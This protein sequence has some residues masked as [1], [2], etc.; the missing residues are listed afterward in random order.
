MKK[1]TKFLIILLFIAEKIAAQD[2][3]TYAGLAGM[4]GSNDGSTTNAKF[5]SP[6][7]ICVDKQG[8]IYVADRYN[9][10]IRKI[11]TAG[12]VS[13]LAGSGAA[14]SNDATG[15]T[16]TFT[17]PWA[18][19]CDTLGNLYVAD[20]K[21][22]KIRKVNSSTGV[23]TT[24]AGTGTFGTTNGS[25]S[26]AQFGFPTGIAVSNDGSIIY[27]SD[28]MTHVIRKIQSGTVSTLAG[29]IYISGNTN[30][31][32]TAAKFDHPYSICLDNSGNIL[33]ADEW[34]NMIRKIT[35]AATVS[36]V[37]GTGASGN[38]NGNALSATFNYPW[39]IEVDST[40]N[41]Y[42]GDGN[43]YTIRKITPA[44]IVSIYAGINGMP[45]FTN[46]SINVATF[47]GV[48]SLAYFKSNH[49]MYAADSYN[50]LIRKIVPVSTVTLTITSNSI[51]N[52]FCAGASVILTASPS[53]LTNYT[54]KEG[55]TVLGT[56]ST[57]VLTLTTLTLGVHNIYCTATDALGYTV[58]SAPINIIIVTSATA[59]ISPAGPVSICQGDS[60]LLTASTGI[61]WQWSTGAST[62]SVYAKN[63]GVYT[64]TVT[65]SGGCSAQSNPVTVTIKPVPTTVQ[66]SND[67]VCPFE[68]GL[69][70]AVAQPGVTYYWF[71]QPTGGSL[72]YTGTAFNS[73]VV[74]Q[75]TPF[76]IELHGSNGCVNP[77]RFA[78]YVIV[79]QKPAASF[80]ISI[81]AAVSNGI[82]IYFYNTTSNGFQYNWNFGDSLSNDN[83]ST[84]EDPSHT[85]STPG[86][87]TIQLIAFNQ[88][89]CADTL[90]K[91]ITVAHNH[92]IFIPT[93]FTPNNDGINDIFRVRGS[94]IKAVSMS[95]F[96][97]WGQ[98]I[99][100][101]DEN[102]WDG[103][104]KGSIVQN[105]TYAYM[106]DVI[107]SNET[108][109]NF[110]G[111]ITVIR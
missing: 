98:R 59:T 22:Y 63:A 51:N 68:S 8:N 43:N 99:F 54:F 104:T 64:V 32:G 78:A 76:Y 10:K 7:G 35:P 45:G 41:I 25:V 73:P 66:A 70:N 17:E 111:Q 5:N 58:T 42:V 71:A 52:T 74:S 29:T 85:Y 92:S 79:D 91:T 3:T 97:Q 39:G 24:V 33:V 103:S 109:E 13:T 12:V 83:T 84:A 48:T 4:P 16:A 26:V 14:G 90:L 110:K 47:N 75:T 62:Q 77:N 1:L 56:S 34:N 101:A 50:H 36:T 44:G 72:L 2:V 23:V 9:N 106:I 86:E 94:N 107:Y 49:S 81:P 61:T 46:G 20:T 95:I 69:I 40:G 100:Q 87:Y 105:G 27:V 67:T 89:G 30:G 28:Y 55:A 82:Q 96:N 80:D 88:H 53:G 6:H 15:A 108:T 19:A 38:T 11:T 31:T 37:A 93:T 18:I 102:L 65:V 21:S 60:A 57:G